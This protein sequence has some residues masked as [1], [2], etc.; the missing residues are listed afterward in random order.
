MEV[1]GKDF[2]KGFDVVIPCLI[3]GGGMVDAVDAA[4]FGG[5]I[6]MYGC[7]EICEEPFDFYKVHYKRL[8]IHSTEP[9]RDIDMRRFFQE[10]V[11][12]VLD[13]L[14]NTSEIV[15]HE[16][17]L[18]DIDRALALRHDQSNDAIHVLVDCESGD[19]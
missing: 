2:P 13:G 18:R 1:V 6:V 7:I 15:T 19:R 11:Q 9:R 16:V 4:A 3:E 12:L 14:V 17:P 8:S 5:R 10:G